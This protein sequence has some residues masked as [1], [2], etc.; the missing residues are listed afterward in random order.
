MATTLQKQD[1]TSLSG[2]LEEFAAGLPEQEKNVLGWI[3]ARSRSA[4]AELSDTALEAVS[5]G[6]EP[7]SRQLEQ[8]AGF[9]SLA[10]GK[11][12]VTTSWTYST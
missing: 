7:L 8:A 11:S 2:K 4:D 3:L 12:S 1:I 5:G 6:S 10:N 9:D